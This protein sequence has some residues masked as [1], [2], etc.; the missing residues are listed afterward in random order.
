MPGPRDAIPVAGTVLCALADVPDPGARG[1]PAPADAPEGMPGVFV[2]HVGGVVRAYVND[3]PHMGLP[4][5]FRPDVFLD[6]KQKAI[7]CANHGASF[8]IE[9]GFC[10]AGPCR[11]DALTVVPVTVEDGHVVVAGR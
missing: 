8:R 4:L 2:V 6:R 1:I 3:C 7:L 5:E 10:T 9:D 11:G